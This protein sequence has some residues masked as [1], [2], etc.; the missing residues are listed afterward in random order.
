MTTCP[1]CQSSQ[2]RTCQAIWEA[3]S[4]TA[5]STVDGPGGSVTAVGTAMTLAAQRCA[6]PEASS[7]GRAG[8]GGILLSIFC[9]SIYWGLVNLF[10]KSHSWLE[11]FG[12]VGL[13]GL[14]YGIF[15]TGRM[16]WRNI[17]Y[18]SDELPGQIEAWKRSWRCD[19]CGATFTPE[20]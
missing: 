7:V 8:C 12:V 11:A 2:V 5:T 15:A 9:L 3:G 16:V 19:A 17:R 13:L 18:N 14:G 6:P 4:S 20:K 1:H 10:V